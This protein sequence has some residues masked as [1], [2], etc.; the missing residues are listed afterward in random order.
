MSV[1]LSVFTIPPK[2]ICVVYFY[3]SPFCNPIVLS[4][5]HYQLSMLVSF[6]HPT[7][8][9][10]FVYF[11]KFPPLP[12]HKLTTLFTL[13]LIVETG[14]AAGF[15][16]LHNWKSERLLNLWMEPVFISCKNTRSVY[17]IRFFQE[18]SP[19]G[20]KKPHAK[21]RNRTR[22]LQHP[23]CVLYVSWLRWCQDGVQSRRDYAIIRYLLL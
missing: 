21:S 16:N 10:M 22:L 17:Y 14:R 2:Q 13:W 3:N 8:K 11:F 1:L 5:H 15:T 23:I 18:K 9:N 7:L 19:I 20:K 4:T 12:Y 6:H